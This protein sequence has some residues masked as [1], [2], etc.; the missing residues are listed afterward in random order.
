MIHP[1]LYTRKI[2]HFDMDAFYAAVEVRDDNS[3]ADIPLVIG[4]S[5]QS[6]GVVC[7]ASYAARKFGIRSAMSCAHAYKLCPHAVFMKPNFAKYKA[8]SAEIRE[9]FT[10]YTDL[11]E[12]LSL[13]EAY[14]DVT[15]AG[16]YATA[17]A[18]EIQIAV[19]N[20]TQLTGSAGVAP[21]KMIAKISSDYS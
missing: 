19:K 18:Q 8:A 9:I 20:E 21:N 13:D 6:R 17:I 7:T 14:L 15:A 2:I 4:G 11:I 3:L 5:P 12:P 1:S 16:R 10:R